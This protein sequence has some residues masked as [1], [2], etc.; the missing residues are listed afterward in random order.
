MIL[1]AYSAAKK[2]AIF[3]DIKNGLPPREGEFDEAVL[4]AGKVK[5]EPLVGSTRYEPNAIFVEFIF[6]DPKSTSTV[7]VVKLTPPERIVFLPVPSWVVENIWQGEIAG[8]FHFESEA[9][10]LYQEL[11]AELNAG[12]NQKWFGPQMAKRRE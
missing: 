9:L 7:F 3:E 1:N 2:M 11:G 8:T 4:R 10:R 5:G 12:Q 6:P